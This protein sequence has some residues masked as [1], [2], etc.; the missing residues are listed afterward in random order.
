MWEP[1]HS[2][3]ALNLE[4]SVVLPND[5]CENFPGEDDLLSKEFE[6]IH[7]ETD[8]VNYTLPALF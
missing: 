2:V 8:N 6:D 3:R 1:E 7:G 5:P 4:R